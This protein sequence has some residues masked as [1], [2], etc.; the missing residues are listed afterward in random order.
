MPT[1]SLSSS[2]SERRLPSKSTPIELDGKIVSPILLGVCVLNLKEIFFLN[3]KITLEICL[4]L[5]QSLYPVMVKYALFNSLQ[6]SSILQ[7]CKEEDCE[8]TVESH[9]AIKVSLLEKYFKYLKYLYE[10]KRFS[11]WSASLVN[12]FVSEL[13]EIALFLHLQTLQSASHSSMI[14]VAR[15]FQ[16]RKRNESGDYYLSVASSV[17]ENAL[18]SKHLINDSNNSRLQCASISDCVVICCRYNFVDKIWSLIKVWTQ[19]THSNGRSAVTSISSD[20]K[21]GSEEVNSVVNQFVESRR[22]FYGKNIPSFKYQ[23]ISMEEAIRSMLVVYYLPSTLVDRC[24][25]SDVLPSYW[26]I[27]LLLRIINDGVLSI[28][29]SEERILREAL[30][31]LRKVV[32]M[33]FE[34]DSKSSLENV[35]ESFANTIIVSIFDTLDVNIAIAFWEQIPHATRHFNLPSS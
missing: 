3:E 30:A 16:E 32:E 29:G 1:R 21:W 28:P 31:D 10:S 35:S 15:Q 5:S 19:R 6:L 24:F 27:L 4:E 17:I 7:N 23:L 9:R 13:L 11:S 26:L 2:A 25:H 8:G 33:I 22:Y 20:Y 18:H 14:V 12:M 34:I